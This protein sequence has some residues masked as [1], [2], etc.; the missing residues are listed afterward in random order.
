MMWFYIKLAWRNLFRNK[1]RTIIAGL[2]I[3]IGLASMMFTD[4]IMIGMKDSMIGSA[5][6]SFLGEAQI[7]RN[8]FRLTQDA[9]LTINNLEDVVAGLEAEDAV[10]NFTPRT[11]SFSMITSSA[12][13]STVMFVGI[14][15]ETER[16]LSQIDEAIQEGS[17]F[18]E[19]NERDIVIGSE[20]AEL[21]EIELGDRIVITVAQAETG[22]LSQEMFRI[23][24]IYHFNIKEMDVGFA[25]A[26]LPKTQEMLGIGSSVHEI[27]IKFKDMTFALEKDSPFWERYS[28]FDNEALSWTE[29]FPALNLIF[30]MLGIT[31]VILGAILFGIVA[32]GIINTL[33][34]SLYERLFEFGVIRAVG[35]RPGG[36]RKI[37]LFE[38]GSLSFV[39]I[40][41]GTVIGLALIFL[42]KKIGIDY[43]G[44]EFAGTTITEM[45]YPVLNIRQFVIYPLATF[46]FTVLVGFYP[47]IVA[48]KMSIS[49]ALRKSM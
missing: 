48:S 25:F 30:G 1:R 27:A 10:E 14:D 12:N 43:R 39:S 38:A 17:Y 29:I 24:G 22:D 2:A 23:S 5:T 47:A 37:V 15:P 41:I 16:F 19:K 11:T 18:E 9:G 34:M 3:G 35:T 13:F 28:A 42:F 4:S 33:F 6:D 26:R 32:F 49:D 46:L 36:V 40:F 20:L 45:L 31:M 44:I 21:L 7:H 8:G